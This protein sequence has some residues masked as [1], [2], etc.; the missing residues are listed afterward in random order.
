MAQPFML[1][2]QQE[3]VNLLLDNA[4]LM[5]S[6]PKQQKP[7]DNRKRTRATAE[8]LAVLEDTFAVTV[9]PNAK[10]RKQLSERLQMSERS[11]QIWF[12]NRRAKVKHMQKKAQIQMQQAAARAQQLLLQQQQHCCCY[13]DASLSRAQSVENL[14]WSSTCNMPPTTTTTTTTSSPGDLLLSPNEYFVPDSTSVLM[15]NTNAL[16]GTTPSPPLLSA[17]GSF[18]VDD[19]HLPLLTGPSP[20][21]EV[22]LC[23]TTMLAIGTWHRFANINRNE[24]LVCAYRPQE[25]VFVWQITDAGLQFEIHVSLDIIH[26]IHFMEGQEGLATVLFELVTPPSFFYLSIAQPCGDF[27][28]GNQATVILRH[29]IQGAA[30]QLKQDL[31]ALINQCEET[32]PLIQWSI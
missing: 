28:E 2:Q 27:T 15:P 32:R 29:L 8:Q 9:S 7:R 1:R 3:D 10:L 26:A 25:R 4:T 13:D 22:T 20:S 18:L 24:Q 21:P 11:I 12:Q 14:D 19:Y 17:A 30:H 23:G 6:K 31:L 16:F 5:S